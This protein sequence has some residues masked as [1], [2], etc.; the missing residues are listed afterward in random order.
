MYAWRTRAWKASR[1]ASSA[2]RASISASRADI[3]RALAWSAAPATELSSRSS[4][5]S[6][7]RNRSGRSGSAAMLAAGKAAS[8]IR[9]AHAPTASRPD[10]VLTP[11]GVVPDR[12]DLE[13]TAAELGPRG[14]H[15][16][17][18]PQLADLGEL[19]DHPRARGVSRRPL[20]GPVLDHLGELGR[21]PVGENL[22]DCAHRGRLGLRLAAAARFAYHPERH[23]SGRPG[24][25][26]GRDPFGDVRGGQSL[27]EL[28]DLAVQPVADVFDLP[29]RLS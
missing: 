6:S 9:S 24:Q 21:P 3:Q 12:A 26:R 4:R 10:P 28:A 20:P 1:A 13:Q 11:K 27:L 8:Q 5:V 7:A 19:E 29:H 18:L 23:G 25:Q 2:A 14:Q 16:I 15:V 22:N 17:H